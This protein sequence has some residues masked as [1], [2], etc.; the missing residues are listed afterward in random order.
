MRQRQNN[1]APSLGFLCPG[2]LGPV[3]TWVIVSALAAIRNDSGAVTLR[4]FGRE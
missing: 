1:E 4:N 3:L 2:F